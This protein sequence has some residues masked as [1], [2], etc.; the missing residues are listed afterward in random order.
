MGVKS[1][2]DIA[3]FPK[4][5]R[6]LKKLKDEAGGVLLPNRHWDKLEIPI[7]SVL[8]TSLVL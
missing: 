7:M 6:A 5:I 3:T 2:K 4:P 1:N 8:Q